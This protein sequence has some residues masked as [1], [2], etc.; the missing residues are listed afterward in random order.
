[1]LRFVSFTLA[2]VAMCNGQ[3]AVERDPVCGTRNGFYGIEG[4]C[5]AYVEC[6]DYRSREMQCP[7]GLH[8]DPAVAWPNY[9]C[10]YPMEVDCAGRGIAQPAQPSAECPHLYGFFPSPKATAD[11]CGYYRMCVDGVAVEMACPPGLAFNPSNARCDWPDTVSTCNAAAFLGFTCPPPPVNEIGELI[12]GPVNY[13]YEGNC[14]AFFSCEEGRA[15]LLSCD[16][17]YGF[18]PI[19]GRCVDGDII[20]C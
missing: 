14:F 5:D 7:D 16:A 2:I 3:I 19:S 13:K 17:G 4:N 1:M 18:D 9:P 11:E 10:G 20:K 6:R 15:R 8:F 12:E